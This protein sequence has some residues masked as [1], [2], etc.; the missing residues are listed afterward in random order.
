L[1][2]KLNYPSGYDSQTALPNGFYAESEI[3]DF[4]IREKKV[5]LRLKRRRWKDAATGKSIPTGED[6]YVAQGTRYSKEFADLIIRLRGYRLPIEQKISPLL[7][8]AFLLK[9]LFN[10]FEIV[11][12]S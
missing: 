9:F 4:P 5:F 3:R 1:E 2:D 6:Q 7:K 12:I 11:D 10:A 8:R